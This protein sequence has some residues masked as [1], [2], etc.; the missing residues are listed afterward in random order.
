[1]SFLGDGGIG[2]SP[3]LHGIA[4]GHYFGRARRR[5]I[6]DWLGPIIKSDLKRILAAGYHDSE[7]MSLLRRIA[8]ESAS[9]P[10]FG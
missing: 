10:D 7:A 1:M 6:R 8:S 2:R 9:D 3:A 5:T 4:L